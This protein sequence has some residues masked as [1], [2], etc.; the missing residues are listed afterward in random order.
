MLFVYIDGRKVFHGR[1]MKI[2][3]KNVAKAFKNGHTDIVISGG[4]IGKWR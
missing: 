4:K 1:D 2:I 3:L